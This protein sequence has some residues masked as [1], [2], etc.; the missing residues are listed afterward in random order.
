MMSL[1]R[2]GRG[3]SRSGDIVLRRFFMI[4]CGPQTPMMGPDLDVGPHWKGHAGM[5]FQAFQTWAF[6]LPPSSEGPI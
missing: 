2:T 1:G 6:T 4:L 3:E 5:T